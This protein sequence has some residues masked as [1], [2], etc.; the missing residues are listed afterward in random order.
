LKNTPK[1][2]KV[3]TVNLFH[4]IP[5][6]SEGGGVNVVVEV[7]AQSRV[8]LKYQPDLNQFIWSRSLSL[9]VCFPYDFGFLPQTIAGDG[10][11][12]DVLVYSDVGSYPGVIVPARVLGALRVEQQRDGQPVKRNDRILVAPIY[13]HRG[14][15][16]TDVGQLPERVTAEIV[17][18]FRASLV[19]TG[20]VVRFKGW[21]DAGEA[22]QIIAAAAQ[23]FTASLGQ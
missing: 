11:A 20:K 4:D 16:L 13:D 3:I 23:R 17:E 7:P 10:D 12:L 2:R 18:F 1:E 22:E 15:H 5:L 14:D 21:A 6:H 8:K 9:G 19:L